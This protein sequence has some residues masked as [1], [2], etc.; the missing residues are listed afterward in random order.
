MIIYYLNIILL[1]LNLFNGINSNEYANYIQEFNN[2]IQTRRYL[3]AKLILEDID[4]QSIFDNPDLDLRYNLIQLKLK[5]TV[6]KNL[7]NQDSYLKALVF[8]QKRDFDKTLKNLKMAIR[9]NPK[10]STLKR[11]YET[12]LNEEIIFAEFTNSTNSKKNY[13]QKEALAILDLMK[14][15]EKYIQYE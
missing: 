15:K 12:V 9:L 10:D 5:D 1:I 3:E 14:R 11:I 8:I 13:S 4:N 6:Y 7:S 2:N